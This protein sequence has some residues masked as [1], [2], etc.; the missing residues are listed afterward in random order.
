M[1]IFIKRRQEYAWF[2][3]SNVVE[4]DE[5]TNNEHIWEQVKQAVTRDVCGSVIVGRT[6]PRS[7]W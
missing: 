1:K 3:K 5:A 6:N 4:W 7:E 2:F